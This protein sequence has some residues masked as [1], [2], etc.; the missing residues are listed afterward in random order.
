M[1]RRLCLG[2]VLLAITVPVALSALSAVAQESSRID[3]TIA[4]VRVKD[5]GDLIVA[6]YSDEDSWLELER[7]FGVQTVPADSETVRVVFEDIPPGE[8]ALQ[9]IHDKNQNGKFDMRWFPYPKP[10]EGAGVSN[11]HVR[12]GKPHHHEALFTVEGEVV[13]LD[14]RLHY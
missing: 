12:K 5:G 9:V 4:P 10:K 14:I 1:P 7:A 13:A 11:D 3:V 6:L 2:C 8:Y